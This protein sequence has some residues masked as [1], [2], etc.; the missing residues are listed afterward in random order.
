MSLA[1]G[2]HPGLLA[3]ERGVKARSNAR[4]ISVAGHDAVELLGEKAECHLLF[5]LILR[6]GGIANESADTSHC[7]T[8]IEK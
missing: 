3:H 4:T 5:C 7:N 6:G 2:M 1:L 8:T